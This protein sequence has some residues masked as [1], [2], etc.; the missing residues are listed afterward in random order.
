MNNEKIA[1]VWIRRDLRLQ[2]HAPLAQ[3]SSLAN[4]LAVVF[5]FDSLILEKIEKEDKRLS[6]IFQSLEEI[7]A[8][9]IKRGSRLIIRHGDPKKEIPLVAKSIGASFVCV[10]KDYEPYAKERDAAVKK[11]LAKE[12]I[13]FI[14]VK[15]QVIF[16]ER[17]IL[18][19]EG[20]PFKVFTPYKN[21]WLQKLETKFYEERKSF[22]QNYRKESDLKSVL[23]RI[24]LKD[25]GFQSTSLW[26]PPGEKAAQ[27]RLNDFLPN[28]KSYFENRNFPALANGTS[29]LSVHLRF[30]TISPRACVRAALTQKNKGHEGW[31]N[32]IVWRDFYHMIL[33][34]FPH[35]ASKAFKLDYE[36]IRWPGKPQH[37]E[38]WCKGETGYPLIDAAMRHFNDT[39]WMH[40]RLR[41]VVASFL[42]KDLLVDWRMGEAYFAKKLLDFDL[43][44]NNGGWQWSAS[45]GCDAQPYFRIFNPYSQSENFDPKGDF[46]RKHVEELTNVKGD[47]IHCPEPLLV[48]SYARPIVDHKEQREKAL[49]LFKKV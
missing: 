16:E 2:D 21:A 43:A 1:L 47:S 34:Q 26:L 10:G 9:L 7:E 29:G 13:E 20:N 15:D 37:F 39:G 18:T 23:Q 25:I 3:A 28:M 46:I 33:D 32:E 14:S 8:N 17:E 19:K 41:M 40:N 35:V 49:S 24:D 44:A 36:K 48:P 12:Q 6:F 38:A 27:K 42:T 22:H 4:S 11:L 30:G 5:V 45:T 31:L